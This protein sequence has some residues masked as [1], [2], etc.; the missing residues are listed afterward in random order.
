MDRRGNIPY[1]CQNND[2]YSN[3]WLAVSKKVHRTHE[4]NTD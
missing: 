2:C 1:F 4:Y 3:V